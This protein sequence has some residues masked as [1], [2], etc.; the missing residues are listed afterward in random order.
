MTEIVH[1]I[2]V[3]ILSHVSR[4]PSALDVGCSMSKITIRSG[5]DDECFARHLH[6]LAP[7]CTNLRLKKFAAPPQLRARHIP[8]KAS[9]ADI[10][11]FPKP[12]IPEMN[13]CKPLRDRQF[14]IHI[15]K[16]FRKIPVFAG[17]LVKPANWRRHPARGAGRSAAI[18]VP[19]RPPRESFLVILPENSILSLR[20]VEPNLGNR[21]DR[22]HLPG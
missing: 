14:W 12:E 18:P 22:T 10:P 7:G 21:Y 20:L 8:G 19:R 11:S 15:P 5:L 16:K 9:P 17:F 2:P 6:L 13:F 1:L 3:R 4:I